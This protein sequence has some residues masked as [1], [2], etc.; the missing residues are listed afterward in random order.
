MVGLGWS[1]QSYVWLLTQSISV[2][3]NLHYFILKSALL[4]PL[5]KRQ[6]TCT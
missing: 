2:E 1:H 5:V 3:S 6:R 4:P